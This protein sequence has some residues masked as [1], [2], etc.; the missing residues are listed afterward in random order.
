M[1]NYLRKWPLTPS[2]T[3]SCQNPVCVRNIPDPYSC[4]TNKLSPA[5]NVKAPTTTKQT[6]ATNVQ[7]SAAIKQIHTATMQKPAGT[8][9]LPTVN[10]Q[11]PVEKMSAATVWAPVATKQIHTTTQKPAT[12]KLLPTANLQ[13]LAAIE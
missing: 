6:S 12:A 10:V 5:I 9:L 7:T 11:A 8:K 4:V 2:T 3:F 13:M 1:K